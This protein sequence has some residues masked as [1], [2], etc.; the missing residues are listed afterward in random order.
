[1][2]AF[3]LIMIIVSFQ[4]LSAESADYLIPAG[5]LL[6]QDVTLPMSKAQFKIKNGEAQLTYELPKYIDGP[7]PQRFRL[8][9]KTEGFPV[10]LSST[11][12]NAT[13]SEIEQNISCVMK[14]NKNE[15]GLFLLDLE[16][17]ANLIDADQTLSSADVTLLKQAGV[18][19]SHEA[20]GII[21][22]KKKK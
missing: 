5:Q 3:H 14:Y 10:E 17:A 11:K 21:T 20:L 13:C 6:P 9:G 18:A 4:S 12:V 7:T 8:K 15:E 2:K 16:G 22:L 1:M 19:L